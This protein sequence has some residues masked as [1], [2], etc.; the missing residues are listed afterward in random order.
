M[1]IPSQKMVVLNKPISTIQN[2]GLLNKVKLTDNKN[3]GM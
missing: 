3:T 2:K 1:M